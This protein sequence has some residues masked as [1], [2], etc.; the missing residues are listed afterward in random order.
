MENRVPRAKG[1]VAALVLLT[2]AG[3]LASLPAL[4][5]EA[6]SNPNFIQTVGPDV[7]VFDMMDVQ[8]YGSSGG[9]RGYAFGTRS[10]NIGDKPLNWCDENGGC[11]N[12]TASNDHP[13]IAQNMYRLKNGRF[14]QIGASWLKHGFLST[15][16]TSSGCGNGS[17]VS[18][19]LGSS[20]L[21][22]GCTDPYQA[23]LNGS[24]PL[25]RRSEVNSTTG[26]YPF[27]YTGGGSTGAVWNQRAAVA[28]ADL[29]PAQNTG[30]TYYIE[31][32]Y[33]APDD[34]AAGNGL[35]N[36]SYRRVTV[37]AGTYNLSMAA[38]T[39]REKSAIEVWPTV[40]NTVEL[41]NVDTP[42]VP[43]ERFHVARKVTDLGGGVW[44]YEYA[45]HNMNSD[46][47]ASRLT[48]TFGN[49]TN[50]TNI[51]FHDVNS[52]SNEP[53]DTTDWEVTTGGTS[54]SWAAPVFV[55][56]E[57]AN[58]L[59]WA[60]MYS[61]WFDA[62]RGPTEIALHT[63]GLFKT[64]TPAE[65]EFLATP[66]ESPFFAD[67]FETGDTSAWTGVRSGR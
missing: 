16:S 26:A 36:A 52:H 2:A 43:A 34:A 48:I 9:V 22:I 39:V 23:S 6:V 14:E 20:Q 55:P 59:R 63:L 13:V 44:H 46:R 64:G 7:T 54:I 8:N 42:S 24:R 1:F 33:I 53:Y 60:T 66:Q 47:S 49:L 29:D 31:G 61:F 10:C 51:G 3:A 67:G 18:P 15:N 19:P 45:I 12:G 65:L 27:P 17:C 50:F 40:D 32:H 56:A 28:E 30:A 35:N 11:G 21:G 41:I 38:S 62:T 25:G 58:A 57:N 37:T 5:Q 4:A